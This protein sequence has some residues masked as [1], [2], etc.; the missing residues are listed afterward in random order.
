MKGTNEIMKKETTNTGILELSSHERKECVP[1]V[2]PVDLKVKSSAVNATEVGTTKHENMTVRQ[3]VQEIN[4]R[5]L[6]VKGFS[7]L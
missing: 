3:L 1:V 4:S 5:N 6:Q 7:K 2:V